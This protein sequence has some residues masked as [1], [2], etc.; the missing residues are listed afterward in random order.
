M[1]VGLK[2]MFNFSLMMRRES[3][4]SDSPYSS[5][6]GQADL[7]ASMVAVAEVGWLKMVGRIIL[8]FFSYLFFP[9]LSVSP[10]QNKINS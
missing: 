10:K 6:M 5:M 9:T 3:G 2:W 8:Y 4:S 1:L 7:N